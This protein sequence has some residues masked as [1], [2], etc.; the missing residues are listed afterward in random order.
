V[1]DR[2]GLFKVY[3]RSGGMLDGPVDTAGAF[4]VIQ[5]QCGPGNFNI[6][7]LRSDLGNFCVITPSGATSATVHIKT[8]EYDELKDGSTNPCVE[9]VL[10]VG[11][12]IPETE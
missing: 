6:D 8:D 10:T 7:E 1:P 11:K 4:Y 9:V 2:N 5:G 12:A 3:F